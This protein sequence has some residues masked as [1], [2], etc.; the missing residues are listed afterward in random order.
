MVRAP[1]DP[2]YCGRDWLVKLLYW[3]FSG[4]YVCVFILCVF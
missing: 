2:R 1:L 3:G 4:V